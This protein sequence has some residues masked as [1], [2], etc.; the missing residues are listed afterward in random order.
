MKDQ[1]DDCQFFTQSTLMIYVL[2]GKIWQSSDWFF[3]S[4]SKIEISLIWEG[5]TKYH[6]PILRKTEKL[7]NS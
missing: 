1:S 3:K 7:N 6:I 4:Y 5:S 2:C